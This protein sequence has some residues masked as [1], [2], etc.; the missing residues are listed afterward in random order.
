[1]FID[2][3]DNASYI[4]VNIK[5]ARI[6]GLNAAVYCSELI[7]IYNKAVKKN[8]IIDDGFFKLDRTYMTNRTTLSVEEQLIIDNTWVKADLLKKHSDNPDI[9]KLNDELLISIISEEDSSSIKKLSSLLKTKTKDETKKTKQA[10]II[11]NLKNS[12]ICSNYELL[13]ALREWVETICKSKGYL[14][15]QMI[16]TF[17]ETLN[18]YTKGDLDLALRLV[19]IATTQCYRDCQW[20][21]NIYEKDLKFKQ[22]NIR[23]TKQETASKDTISK[24]FVF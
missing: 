4:N 15:I 16:K 1:M 13:T 9:I 23:I 20:A 3:L 18:N 11:E 19:K 2:L 10:I 8:K 17:Q 22:N 24:K 12:I 14:S 6:F 7:N 21:I 5:L